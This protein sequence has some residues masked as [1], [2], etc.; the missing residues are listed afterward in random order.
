M[1]I[2][3]YSPARNF[4]II[5]PIKERVFSPINIEAN[6]VDEAGNQIVDESGNSIIFVT[7]DTVQATLVRGQ[8]R[9]FRII[10]PA[11]KNG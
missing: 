4:R 10:S 6:W 8:S 1:P 11:R 9:S 2:T 5:A 3:I 7:A